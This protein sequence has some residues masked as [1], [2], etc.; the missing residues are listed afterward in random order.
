MIL[1]S[2]ETL[3]IRSLQHSI[4]ILP[5]YLLLRHLNHL[6]LEILDIFANFFLPLPDISYEPSRVGDVS[7]VADR[8]RLRILSRL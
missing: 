5:M 7:T 3:S 4:T 8:S 2:S 6:S 1:Y